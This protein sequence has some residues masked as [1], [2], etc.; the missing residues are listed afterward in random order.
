MPNPDTDNI[1]CS[2]HTGTEKVR[3]LP[4]MCE[5]GEKS[6]GR[7]GRK[8]LPWSPS[9]HHY[10]HVCFNITKDR[11]SSFPGPGYPQSRNFPWRQRPGRQLNSLPIITGVPTG[12]SEGGIHSSQVP[13][14]MPACSSAC[15]P[16]LCIRFK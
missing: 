1:P 13:L 12:H 7:P 11:Y 4:P 15:F 9:Q 3:V 6:R 14:L 8:Q 16:E 10:L 2:C 5:L